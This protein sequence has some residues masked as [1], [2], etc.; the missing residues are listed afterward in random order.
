VI[1]HRDRWRLHAPPTASLIDES[2]L[3]GFA[4][5]QHGSRGGLGEAT[6][7]RP[8]ELLVAGTTFRRDPVEL[9]HGIVNRGITEMADM[10]ETT[11]LRDYRITEIDF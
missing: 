3:E 9:N 4:A 5:A 8:I 2:S 10:A 7:G 1:R 11:E 6:L